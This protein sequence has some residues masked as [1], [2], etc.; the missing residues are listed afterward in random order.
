[1]DA[2][3]AFASAREVDGGTGAS[4]VLMGARRAAPRP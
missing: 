2:V 1:V 4:L 3:L